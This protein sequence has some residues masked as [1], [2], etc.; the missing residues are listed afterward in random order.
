MKKTPNISEA[1]WEVMRAVWA[2]NPIAANEVVE[3]VG[4]VNNWNPK[5]VKT[6]LNRL[7]KKKALGFRQI[8]RAYEYYP[9]VEEADCV[10]SESRTF[11]QRV[12]GGSLTPMLTHFLEAESLT[13]EEIDELRRILDEKGGA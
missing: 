3:A 4:P 6:M 2:H 7:V 9:L 12:Y 10:Q 1:E 8:G 13:H 11:L 5:T